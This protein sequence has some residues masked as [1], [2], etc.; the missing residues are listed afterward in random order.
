MMTSSC[1]GVTVKHLLS[2]RF[3]DYLPKHLTG[4][5][6]IAKVANLMKEIT[7]IS[8][9]DYHGE[10]AFRYNHKLSV[11][12]SA[13]SSNEG[14]MQATTRNL[15]QEAERHTITTKYMNINHKRSFS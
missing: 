10:A 11:L 5:G 15:K 14:K 12:E 4:K 2:T 7:W 6:S 9:F 13:D 8:V 3:R 1:E